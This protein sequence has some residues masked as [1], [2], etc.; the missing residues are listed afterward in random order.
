MATGL[1]ATQVRLLRVL[2]PSVKKVGHL[3]WNSAFEDC[4]REVQAPYLTWFH[5]SLEENGPVFSCDVLWAAP[6]LEKI[7]VWSRV[8]GNISGA[9]ALQ[10]VSAVL[11]DGGLNNLEGVEMMDCFVRDEDYVQFLNA[12]EKSYSLRRIRCLWFEGCEISKVGACALA[13]L[14]ARNALPALA[15]LSFNENAINDAGVVALAE[16]LGKARWSSRL[17]YLELG[18]VGMG[19]QGMAALAKL[20]SQG[21]LWRVETLDLLSHNHNLTDQGLLPLVQAIDACGLRMLDEFKLG[22]LEGEGV[23]VA[24]MSAVVQ[25]VIRKCRFLKSIVLHRDQLD[26][27]R[28]I[29]MIKGLLQTAGKEEEVHLSVY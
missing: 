28:M 4:F 10:S 26:D 22:D 8:H 25:A 16:S 6:S 29:E 23:T 14:L 11:R 20:V 17:M 3:V 18:G 1:L 24:G 9:T 21:C 13:G 2:L 7:V 19:D 5:V 27:T 15:E 12:L